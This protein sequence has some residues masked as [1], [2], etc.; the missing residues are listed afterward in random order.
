MVL[1]TLG[2]LGPTHGYGI[3]RRIEQ[4]AEDALKVNRAPSTSAGPPPSAEGALGQLGHLREQPAGAVL[5]ADGG[6]E[7]APAGRDRELGGSG[8]M[9]RMQ[10]LQKVQW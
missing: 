2:A 4:V 7:A 3:A 10:Q 5:H 8:V 9:R 6:A 1:K